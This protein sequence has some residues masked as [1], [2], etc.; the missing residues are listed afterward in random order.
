[1]R[2]LRAFFG[3][4]RAW[5]RRSTFETEMA[6][7]MRL[8]LEQR[9]DGHIRAGLSPAEARVAAIRAFGGVA[10]IQDACRDQRRFSSIDGVA[11]DLRHGV[12]QLTR[13]PGFGA[14]AVLTFA[15]G[16]GAN[17]VVFSVA[18]TVLLGPLGFEAPEQLLWV[19]QVDTRTGRIDDRVS[20]RDLEDIRGSTRIFASLA[21]FGA[22]SATWGR[23]GRFEELPA[24]RVSPNL[25]EVLR[26]RPALGRLLIPSDAEE[27]AAPVVVISHELWQTRFGGATDIIGQALRLDEGVYTVVGVLPRGLQFPL[28]DLSGEALRAALGGDAAHRPG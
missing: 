5:G 6:E 14:I 12:R 2:S 26:I 17:T 27:N 28:E 8:H 11:Q 3:V 18:T 21:L 25:A 15:L 9:V 23:D 7:E 13:H 24:L 20:S 22:G 19:R 1:M 16:I 10:Q 4:V